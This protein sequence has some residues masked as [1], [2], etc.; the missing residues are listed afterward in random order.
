[1]GNRESR[2]AITGGR[3]LGDGERGLDGDFTDRQFEHAA[4]SPLSSIF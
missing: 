2:F 3:T 4:A 1:M